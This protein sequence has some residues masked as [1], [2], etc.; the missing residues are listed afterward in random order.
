[1]LSVQVLDL[2][3]VEFWH[4][5][6]LQ[7]VDHSL[8]CPVEQVFLYLGLEILLQLLLRQLSVTIWL[9]LHRPKTLLDCSELLINNETADLLCLRKL[10]VFAHQSSAGLF[11]VRPA[12]Q[13][14]VL[15]CL[16]LKS[17]QLLQNF[18]CFL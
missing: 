5:V 12:V 13:L 8:Q 9:C 2:P 7:H 3:S 15:L 6:C 17:L 11:R 16:G 14:V 18:A 10:F 1:M 4:V